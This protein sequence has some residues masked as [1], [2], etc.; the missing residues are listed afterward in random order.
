MPLIVFSLP[1]GGL[2]HFV[3]ALSNSYGLHCA[4][5]LGRLLRQKFGA[6]GWLFNGAAAS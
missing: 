6:D 5:S 2:R 4:P 1:F 3:L